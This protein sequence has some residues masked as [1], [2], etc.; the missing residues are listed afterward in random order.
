MKS[1]SGTATPLSL[2]LL[3][4]GG[5]AMDRRGFLSRSVALAALGLLAGACD[6]TGSLTGPVLTEDVMVTLSDYPALAQD[7]GVVRISGVS[8]PVAVANLGSD[9]YVALSL[10]CP[11]AGGLVGWTGT[12]FVCPV[13]GAR[14]AEDGHW[15]GGQPTSSLREYPT[16]YDPETD[17][18]TI[19]PRG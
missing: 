6:N 2:P 16:T 18:L 3:E 15:T 14:F 13:H 12:Q 4:E 5:E 8:A 17:T 7:G 19:H 11:H 9:M 1:P 10:V